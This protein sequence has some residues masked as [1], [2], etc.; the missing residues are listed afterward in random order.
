V[1]QED[2]P[3]ATDARADGLQ[4][5]SLVGGVHRFH[6]VAPSTAWPRYTNQKAGKKYRRQP[7]PQHASDLAELGVGLRRV[8]G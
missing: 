5:T 3:V 2:Q 8:G 6:A 7:P 4:P 1:A